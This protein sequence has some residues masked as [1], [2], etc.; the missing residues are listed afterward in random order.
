MLR[1]KAKPQTSSKLLRELKTPKNGGWKPKDVL[2]E[3]KTA[4]GK[5]ESKFCSDLVTSCPVPL[6]DGAAFFLFGFTYRWSVRQFFRPSTIHKGTASPSISPRKPRP[7]I[8]KAC[9]KLYKTK[10]S[11]ILNKPKTEADRP[12]AFCY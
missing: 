3:T 10:I 12:E 2:R 9:K 1:P 4:A 5:T 6:E 8:S 7:S 11:A